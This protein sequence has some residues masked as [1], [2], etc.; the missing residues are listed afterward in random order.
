MN[1][2]LIKKLEEK[3]KERKIKLENELASFAKKDPKT[4]GDY[5]TAFPDAGPSQGSDEE[6]V[7]F[8]TYDNTLPVEYALEL[9][10][11]EVNKALDKT[12]EGV[13]GLC[14]K[15]GK[16]IDPKRLEAMP[17]AKSCVNCQK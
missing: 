6:A 8:A 3:L 13:Y 14:E 9:R 15:C 10:L 2:D 17:E 1:K 11:A 4:P 12:K 5:D 16:E 7:K